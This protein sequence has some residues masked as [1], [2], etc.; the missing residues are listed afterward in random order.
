MLVVLA[1]ASSVVARGG[2]GVP[3]HV[4]SMLLVVGQQLG[5]P[6]RR[7][8]LNVLGHTINQT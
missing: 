5:V 7:H 3:V 6:Y 4:R 8:W 1:M 2:A